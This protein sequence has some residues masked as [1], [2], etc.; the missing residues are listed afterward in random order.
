M[1]LVLP[2]GIADNPTPFFREVACTGFRGQV[3][4][5]DVLSENEAEAGQAEFFAFVF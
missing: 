1:S 2:Y 3:F 5:F 4:T